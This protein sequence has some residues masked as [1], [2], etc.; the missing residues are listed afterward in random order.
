MAREALSRASGRIACGF[1]GTR[2]WPHKMVE[3][4][5]GYLC[6]DCKGAGVSLKPATDKPAAQPEKVESKPKTFFCAVCKKP[7]GKGSMTKSAIGEWV[8]FDCAGKE[9]KAKP[10]ARPVRVSPKY[11]V[12]DHPKHYTSGPV[13]PHCGKTVECITVTE[14]YN[15]N[16]GNAIKY[17][18]RAGEKDKSR[19]LEDLEKAQWYITREI[20][21]VKAG[22]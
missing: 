6:K 11:S 3:T 5:G 10:E 22:K 19:E 12:V 13:C 16:R 18:W 4:A 7:I 2:D 9:L 20:E 17:I 1:C 15:F 8:C 14:G 21:R